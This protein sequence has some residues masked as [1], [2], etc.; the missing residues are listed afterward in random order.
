MKRIRIGCTTITIEPNRLT[1]TL[2][3]GK[4]VDAVPHDTEEYRATAEASGY[5]SDLAGMNR[6][7]ELSH[8]ILAD[9]LGMAESPVMRA[10]ADDTWRDDPKGLLHLEEQAAMS[11]QKLA[12]AYGIDLIGLGFGVKS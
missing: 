3:D 2:L 10:V 6:D 11:L 4:Q 9:A 7:H 12:R 1:S 5:G 8:H